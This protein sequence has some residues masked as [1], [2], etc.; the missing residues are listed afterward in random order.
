MPH[1]ID[2][3]RGCIQKKARGGPLITMYRDDPGVYYYNDSTEASEEAAKAA[4]FNTERHRM[5][6]IREQMRAEAV[7][8]V[9]AKLA[10]EFKEIDKRA[11]AEAK[12]ID[13]VA[14]EGEGPNKVTVRCE[15]GEHAGEPRETERLKMD[16]FGGGVWNVIDKADGSV[17]ATKVSREEAMDKLREGVQ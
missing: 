1:N 12:R 16:H 6:R 14:W 13:Y 15:R 5:E 2:L 3:D 4:N 10:E 9:D 17:I 8:E 11:E 7:A